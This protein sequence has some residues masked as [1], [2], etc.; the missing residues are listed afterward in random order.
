MTKETSRLGRPPKGWSGK[1][2]ACQ[3][4]VP[5]E[6]YKKLRAFAKDEAARIGYPVSIAAA[7]RVLLEDRFGRSV[8]EI[9]R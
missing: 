9:G 1:S 8:E 3:V 2:G 7:L 4:Y 5:A 6:T